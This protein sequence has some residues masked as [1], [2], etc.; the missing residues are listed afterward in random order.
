MWTC[1][2]T[3]SFIG[4]FSSTVGTVMTLW[5]A[6]TIRKKDIEKM[7]TCEGMDSGLMQKSLI[8]HRP[9]CWLGFILIILGTILQI[10]GL[11]A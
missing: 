3:L 7:R 9:L 2:I 11:F 10:A 8:A 5:S 4:I 1:S 6:L